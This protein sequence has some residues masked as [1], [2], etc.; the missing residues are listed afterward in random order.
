MA[1]WIDQEYR[2]RRMAIITP[3]FPSE[4]DAV[5]ARYPGTTLEYCFVCGEPTGRAGKGDDSLYDEDDEGPY[6]PGCWHE[7]FPEED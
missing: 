7:A 4:H 5:N 6:C 2:R 1:D 3:L